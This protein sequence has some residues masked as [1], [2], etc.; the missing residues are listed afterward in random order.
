MESYK[1]GTV[2]RITNEIRDKDNNLFD[3]DSVVITI[4]DSS[5]TEKI[6]EAA[7]TQETTGKYYY[8]W[9]SAITDI[10]GSYR[11]KVKAISGSYTAI[12]EKYLFELY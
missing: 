5:E 3:P 12:N 2:I 8:N 4:T 9:Q 7:M 10:S 6:T 1:A 11:I